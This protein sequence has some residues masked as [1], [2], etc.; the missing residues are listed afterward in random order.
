M[1]LTDSMSK[2][3]DD[4]GVNQLLSKETKLQTWLDV[5]S[6]LATAQAE[7]GVI[8]TWAAE[9]IKKNAKFEKLDLDKMDEI[10]RKVGHGFVPFVKVFV[11][12]C[13]E[14][15]G[16]YI[17]YGSTTQN[18]QQSA[19]NIILKQLN[20]K[21]LDLTK[22]ILLNLADIAEKNASTVMAGRTHGKHAIPIT[23]GYKVSTWMSEILMSVERLEQ[24]EPRVFTI[25]M[26]G[27]VGAFNS[28][29]KVGLD[30]QKRVGELLDMDVMMI[31]SRS[32]NS[33]KIEYINALALLA[34]NFHK[35]A[36]EV[37]QTSIEEFG[38][39]SE[40]F[41]KGTIGSST[42]P[43]KINPKL[44]K[45]IIA[46]AQKLYSLT[47][48]GY[49]SSA[50]PFEADSTSNMLFDGLLTDSVELMREII[51]RTV[52][53]TKTLNIHNERLYENATINHGIDNSE[54]IMMKL[55]EKIGKDQAHE[56][57]YELAIDAEVNNKK[58]SEVLLEHELLKSMFSTEELLEL[59][60]PE[61]Y[62]GLSKEITL[63]TVKLIRGTYL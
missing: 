63:D 37:F 51:I 25:M 40:N 10:Y 30:V 15:S 14:E 18:I 38:E 45:G 16:K 42:M 53:L 20:Q 6:A 56:M 24:L 59:L 17:H 47:Q 58:Y 61:N 2:T 27:A 22:S 52:D 50:R 21:F 44:S 1:A 32:I 8:P 29:G 4:Y 60:K 43:H 41:K 55:A 31:P 3:L 49:F 23:F 54:Y 12:A 48:V 39:V 35:I 13:D 62:I 46:N 57:V 9:N 36:E 28:T 33:Q 7:Y 19:Q 34:N 26:G 11:Q 5:E